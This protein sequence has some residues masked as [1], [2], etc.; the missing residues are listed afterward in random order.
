MPAR[1]TG[2]IKT[3]PDDD[4]LVILANLGLTDAMRLNAA[5]KRLL[6]RTK[7]GHHIL[8]RTW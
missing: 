3:G 1:L 4:S 7:Y 5:T 8:G 6:N 2:D